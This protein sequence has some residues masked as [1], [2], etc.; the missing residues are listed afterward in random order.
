MGKPQI[1]E[2]R[3]A[4]WGVPS[5]VMIVVTTLLAVAVAAT[6]SGRAMMVSK[7]ASLRMSLLGRASST[8]RACTAALDDRSHA[9]RMHSHRPAGREAAAVP[10]A[11]ACTPATP[12]D[13]RL[14]GVSG[15]RRGAARR[16]ARRLGR[17][18]RR[19]GR[20]QQEN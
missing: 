14:D 4:K 18:A 7:S 5:A 1:L 9:A 2:N 19:P 10:H 17:L 3:G 11:A 13:A 20:A 16:R 8:V 12:R 15:L 6:A